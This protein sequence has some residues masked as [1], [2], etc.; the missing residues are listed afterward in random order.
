MMSVG[1]N[2]L[3]GC[4]HGADHHLHASCWAWSPLERFT[5]NCCKWCL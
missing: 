2:F 3:C 5:D 4:P 1:S